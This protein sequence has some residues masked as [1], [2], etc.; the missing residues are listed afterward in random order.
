MNKQH[1]S[2]DWADTIRPAILKRDNYHCKKCRVKHRA[3]GYYENENTFVECDEFMQ[4]YAKMRDFKLIKIILQ[5]HHKNGNKKDND[6]KNLVSLCPKCH[7][8]EEAAFNQLKRKM[9]G[10]I[11]KKK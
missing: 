9:K 10:I 1:Y 7:F 5:V 3:V 2:K 6:F 8:K 11:Y 4:G